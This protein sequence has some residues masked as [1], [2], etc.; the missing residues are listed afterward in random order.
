ML[1]SHFYATEMKRKYLVWGR[2][3]TEAGDTQPDYTQYLQLK[4]N[5]GENWLDWLSYLA[6]NF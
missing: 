1:W 5:L 6:G 3:G 4:S 2:T